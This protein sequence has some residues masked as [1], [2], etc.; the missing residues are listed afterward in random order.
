MRG[1][2]VGIAKGVIGGLLVSLGVALVFQSAGS[3]LIEGIPRDAFVL[4]GALVGAAFGAFV[5][6]FAGLGARRSTD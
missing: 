1:V 6:S 5:G 3:A 2:E 4:V